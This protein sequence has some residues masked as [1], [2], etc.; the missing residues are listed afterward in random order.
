MQRQRLA[1]PW[2]ILGGPVNGMTHRVILPV[3]KPLTLKP[4]EG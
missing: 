4:A 3:G 1:C 2:Y